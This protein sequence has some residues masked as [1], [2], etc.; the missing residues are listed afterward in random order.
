MDSEGHGCHL[1]TNLMKLGV[2][3][4]EIKSTRLHWSLNQEA[5]K[6]HQKNE[7][8]RVQSEDWRR[9]ESILN[10]RGLK[11]GKKGWKKGVKMKIKNEFKQGK[12]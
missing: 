9:K 4:E 3:L 12:K 5:K 6:K 8:Q 7:K 11:K 2:I 10:K 1:R